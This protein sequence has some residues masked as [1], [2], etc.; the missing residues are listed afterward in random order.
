[1]GCKS[2]TGISTVTVVKKVDEKPAYFEKLSSDGK[3]YFIACEDARSREEFSKGKIL[4][5][6]DLQRDSD[7]ASKELPDGKYEGEMKDGN[8]NGFGI[9]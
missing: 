7:V 1:M 9:L 2:S 8:A 6:D 5:I 4:L 3:K